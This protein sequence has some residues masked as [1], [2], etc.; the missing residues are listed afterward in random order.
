MQA[1]GTAK[2][3]SAQLPPIPQMDK[4]GQPVAQDAR[5]AV[6]EAVRAEVQAAVA[7]VPQAPQAPGTPKIAGQAPSSGP[8][9]TS[10]QPAPFPPVSNND[11]P[12]QVVP[13]LG[14]IFGTVMVMVLGFPIV[15]VLARRFDRNTDKLKSGA[16]EIT[17]Q[18]RQLQDSVDAMAIEIERISEAQ[19]FTAKLLS[20]RSAAPSA[21]EAPKQG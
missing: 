6:R 21:I 17:P 2:S 11:I 7:G 4:A 10:T 16:S 3:G 14:I 13:M 5:Q 9:T 15:R 19:R 18:L 12:D 1:Q 8:T 20:E